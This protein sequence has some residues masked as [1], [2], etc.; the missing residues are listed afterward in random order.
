MLV[1]FAKRGLVPLQ[2]GRE[3]MS[4]VQYQDGPWLV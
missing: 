1:L 3:R 4:P 2:A